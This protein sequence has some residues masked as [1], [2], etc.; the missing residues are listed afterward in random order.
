MDSSKRLAETDLEWAVG[1]NRTSLK[2]LGL[3]PD[4]KLTRR[5]SL[6]ADARAFSIFLLMMLTAILPQMFAMFHVWGD[7]MAFTDNLQLSVPFS[8]T[9][10]KFFIMWIR[11]EELKP[12]VNMIVNDWFKTKTALERATMIKQ[13]RIARTIVMLGGIMMTLASIILIIPP[14][15][16]Y[17]M[18]YVTNITDL[19]KPLLLQSYFF[20]EIESPFFE[21]AFIG[22]ALSISLAA[23]SYTGIDNFLGLVVFHI[24]AQ[25]DLLKYRLLNLH[26][27]R[28]F[29]ASLSYNVKDHLRLIRS[30]DAIDNTFNL[31]LLALLLFFG[32]LFCMQ[33]FLIIS[34]IDG[35]G[36]D[37]S[38]MRI[39]WLVSILIN[40][41]AHMCLYCIVG[42]ILIAKCD[43]VYYATYGL[44]WYT[45]KPNQARDMMLMMIRAEKPLYITAGRI[46][47]MTMSLFCSVRHSQFDKDIG[48]IY[49]RIAY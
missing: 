26:N 14:C 48:W 27:F 47:P 44:A 28:D 42:E 11:K 29:N 32:I 3:W 35:N 10:M 12:L 49:I 17:S 33:G 5:Q 7:I 23:I 31:M 4:D 19:G 36:G 38:I 21:V 30:V 24:C 41:F 6:V 45:L 16:G 8:V 46:F 1:I 39:C 18:R 25:L 13:A 34:I 15:F 43:G 9:V 40:T 2:I 20:R 37:V 22:Q